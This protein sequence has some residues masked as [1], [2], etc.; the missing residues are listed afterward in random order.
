MKL[1]PGPILMSPDGYIKSFTREV[2][3]KNP[4]QLKI[5]LLASIN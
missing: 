5:K 3:E 2:I 4:D 1:P